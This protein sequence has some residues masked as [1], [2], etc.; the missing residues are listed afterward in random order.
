MY[1]YIY[2]SLC[3]CKTQNCI[4]SRCSVDIGDS[5]IAPLG[6][7]LFVCYYLSFPIRC[8]SHS[9]YR[10]TVQIQQLI[11]I[12]SHRCHWKGKEW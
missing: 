5:K 8:V 3:Q 12:N 9:S 11:R 6:A 7:I 1:I 2:I 4:I 10:S